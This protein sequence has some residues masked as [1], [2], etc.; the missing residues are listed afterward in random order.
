MILCILIISICTFMFNT[1][2]A[3]AG[4]EIIPFDSDE[5]PLG[6][7][8][9]GLNNIY[10]T[11]WAIANTSD[12][13]YIIGGTQAGNSFYLVKVDASGV[14]QWNQTYISPNLGS[15]EGRSV[16][17]TEDGGYALLG[18]T[19]IPGNGYDYWLL[20]TDSD[21]NA[22]WNQTYGY[23]GLTE[24]AFS[25]VQ[26]SDGY[27]LGGY[28]QESG[29]S[30]INMWLIKTDLAGVVQWDKTFGGSGD[31]RIYS[32][33]KT[34]DG[35]YALGGYTSSEYGDLDV[36]LV[37]VDSEGNAQ[38]NKTYGTQIN[39]Y[40]RTLVVTSDG[41]FAL[42]GT[43]RNSYSDILL[44]KTDSSGNQEWN[45]T[46]G[47]TTTNIFAEGSAIVQA[48]DG[49][50]ALGGYRMFSSNNYLSLFFRTDASGNQ[51]SNKSLGYNEESCAIRGMVP[52]SYGYA[53]A[54]TCYSSY[55]Y[56]WFGLTDAN[57][58]TVPVTTYSLT[59]HTV[60]Q[61]TV[62]PGNQTY[63]EGTSVNLIAIAADGW[64]FSGWSG[65]ASGVSNTSTTMSAAK[66]VTATFT[67]NTQPTPTPTP[68]PE[69]TQNVT[70]HAPNLPSGQNWTVNL[71]GENKTSTDDTITFEVAPGTYNYTIYLP[72]GYAADT[73]VTGTTTSEST[74]TVDVST[75]TEVTASP[76]PTPTSSPS[77]NPTATP[78]NSPT[79]TPTP[80]PTSTST[81]PV[82]P[83][84]LPTNPTATPIQQTTIATGDLTTPAT[85]GLAAFLLCL[86]IFVLVTKRRKQKN[87]K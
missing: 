82:S 29:K 28:A 46:Y 32:I 50:Y 23:S 76:T 35:G 59:M 30:T 17:Q 81:P 79:V 77:S 86:A 2:S 31:D 78:T 51:I 41:G 67:E 75:L 38:W 55:S 18:Y 37:K 42:L 66:T 53:F 87:W 22:E 8:I 74:Q 24:D 48:P 26:A 9:Y 57:G 33:V 71:N 65:D 54:G 7:W 58:N 14:M 25:I 62:Q 34:S 72:E 21:G 5:Q 84:N 11:G 3:T 85:V 1:N 49:G 45:K 4:T 80:S 56:V 12:G 13:G 39:D 63:E 27:I 44:I 43:T 19:T 40:C 6:S 70:F 16:I 15:T 20:K 68:T 83:T 69:P 36:W 64:T 61:G 60:G 10:N 73:V 47:W 52:T